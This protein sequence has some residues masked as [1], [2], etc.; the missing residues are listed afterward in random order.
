MEIKK[1]NGS[2]KKLLI[3]G[4]AVIVDIV[5]AVVQVVAYAFLWSYCLGWHFACHVANK[6]LTDYENV[7]DK[8][9]I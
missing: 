9:R 1:L 8:H 5:K 7:V 4:V 3:V 6:N 2:Q